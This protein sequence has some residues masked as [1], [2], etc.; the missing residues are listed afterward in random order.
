MVKCNHVSPALCNF[1]LAS[2]Q[3]CPPD[4][5]SW[6]FRSAFLLGPGSRIRAWQS[7][8]SLIPSLMDRMLYSVSG[9]QDWL[10]YYEIFFAG[11]VVEQ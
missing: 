4:I 2:S 9:N 8:E 5:H 6:M 11:K 1:C 10:G 3:G 7:G